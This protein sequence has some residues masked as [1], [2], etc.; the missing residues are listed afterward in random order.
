MVTDGNFD[1]KVLNSPL[2]VLLF[3]WAPW[4]PTCGAAAPIIDQFAAEAK[5]KIRVGKLNVDANPE[6]A[7]RFSILSVPFLFIFDNG[8]MRESIPGAL[9]KHELML[10]MSPYI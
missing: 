5:G 2:P 6:L 7:S 1:A 3:A 10:R 9:Q 8:E 4:C